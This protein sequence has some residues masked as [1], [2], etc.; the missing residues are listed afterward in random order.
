MFCPTLYTP[1]IWTFLGL[2]GLRVKQLAISDQNPEAIYAVVD[3]TQVS[4]TATLY[5]SIDSGLT[6]EPSSHGISGRVQSLFVHPITPTMLL[7]GAF[8]G[9]TGVYRSDD[10][11]QYWNAAGLD[12][13]IRVLAAHPTSPTLWLAASY[14][15]LVFGF[16][17]AYRTEN[18][19]QNWQTVIPTTTVLDSFA[20]DLDDPGRAYACSGS[21]FLTSQDAGLAWTHGN[22]DSCGELLTHPYSHTIMYAVSGNRILKTDD[23]GL[24]WTPLLSG[25][26]SFRSLALDPTS[27]TAMYAADLET[28]FRSTNAGNSWQQVPLPPRSAFSPILRIW[29]SVTRDGCM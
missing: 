2:S 23:K 16:A 27:P 13:F 3:T 20:F 6:W 10:G 8:T 22:P 12:P 1:P 28:L 25:E 7:A 11:G 26:H 15:P 21:G 5:K 17:Y 9:G 29:L 14:N 24:N 4:T 19:G 18:S